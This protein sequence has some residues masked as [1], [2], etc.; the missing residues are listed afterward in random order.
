MPSAVRFERII[1]L[2]SFAALA[3]RSKNANQSRRLLSLAAVREGKDREEAARDRRHGPPNPA[4]LG[5]PL[6]CRGSARTT[7]SS[8]R[9]A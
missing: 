3:K 1:R 2:W 6:Q 8:G 4:R 7:R 9:E 5:S